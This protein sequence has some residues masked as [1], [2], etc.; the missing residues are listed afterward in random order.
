MRVDNKKIKK[1][2]SSKFVTSQG[3]NMTKLEKKLV[4]IENGVYGPEV[5]SISRE[6]RAEFGLDEEDEDEVPTGMLE[7]KAELV[8]DDD[9]LPTGYIDPSKDITDIPVEDYEAEP[10]EVKPRKRKKKVVEEDYDDEEEEEED[11]DEEEEDDDD[12]EEED[13]E[14]RPNPRVRDLSKSAKKPSK[15]TN[16]TNSKSNKSAS[17]QKTSGKKKSSKAVEEDDDEPLNIRRP[18]EPKKNPF[19][20]ILG[21]IFALIFVVVALVLLKKQGYLSKEFLDNL[22][23]NNQS[24]ERSVYEYDPFQSENFEVNTSNV[25]KESIEMA[26]DRLYED[27]ESRAELNPNVTEDA[28]SQ[29]EKLLSTY[30]G[31]PNYEETPYTNLSNELLTIRYYIGDEKLYQDL[32]SGAV[33]M[34]SS[35]WN[36][37]IEDIERDIRL[38][39]VEGLAANM[40]AKVSVL[41]SRAAAGLPFGSEVQEFVPP[42]NPASTEA[43]TESET[44]TTTPETMPTAKPAPATQS[45]GGGTGVGIGGGETSPSNDDLKSAL[46]GTP[47]TQGNEPETTATSNK[48]NPFA[49]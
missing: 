42:T 11:D 36:R 33:E 48:I 3:N 23:G 46:L 47:S 43:L 45:A 14:D 37:D 9:E 15:K 8:D 16:K 40:Q 28:L 1:S 6:E 35:E 27:P 12:E 17:K 49:D 34:G 30:R 44:S 31:S 18:P 5:K 4:D 25:T 38:Y 24:T 26:L 19:F 39:N 7:G 10:E 21:V 32:R 41:K 2:P 20:I 13:E 29:V 22:L